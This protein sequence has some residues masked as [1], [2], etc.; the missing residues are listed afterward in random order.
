M[1]VPS[2]SFIEQRLPTSIERGASGGPKFKT[3][4]VPLES[5]VEGRQVDWEH[6][7]AEWDVSYGLRSTEDLDEVIGLFYACYGRAI[8]FR[9]RD[10]SDYIAGSTSEP[11]V[12]GIGDGSTTNFQAS[13]TYAI[14]GGQYVRPL[15]KLVEGTY[16][17]YLDGVEETNVNVDPNT[18][19]VEVLSAPGSEVEVGLVSEFDVPVRFDSDSIEKTL[20]GWDGAMSIGSIPIIEVRV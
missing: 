4:I 8:G 2:S 18:G 16:T 6:A 19:N 17:V 12:I 9:F 15:N 7:R 20:G 14:I 3:A 5:G 11:E 13:K 10:W 1:P